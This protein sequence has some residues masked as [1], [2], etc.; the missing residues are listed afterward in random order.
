MRTGK[1]KGY[2]TELYR[3]TGRR[4]FFYSV[5][6]LA[7][8]ICWS[9][10]Y[11]LR[12]R[13]QSWLTR[14]EIRLARFS[15]SQFGED[16]VI[17]EL[18]NRLGI[19]RGFYVDVGAF[20]PVIGSNTLLLFKSGWSGVNIDVE[21]EKIRRFRRI[22]PRDWNVVCGVSKVAGRKTFARYS[23]AS[24]TRMINSADTRS[25]VGDE[26]VYT[27]EVQTKPLQLILNESPFHAKPIDF[28]NIDCE[29]ADL[30]VLQS[31]DFA[32]NQPRVVAVEALDRPAERDI[33]AFMRL[34]D[35]EMTHRLGLTLLFLP[36]NEIVALGE[37]YRKFVETS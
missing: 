26:A 12:N 19:K 4:T 31:L 17:E 1:F 13:R 15:F 21:E 24:V 22:R 25:V 9:L 23:G 20:D 11:L 3:M 34:K 16:L 8:L 5:S 18:V 32:V 14:E 2:R 6:E 7:A 27:F 33:C 36:R 29:G 35:Y 37:L 30:E 28:L 10:L